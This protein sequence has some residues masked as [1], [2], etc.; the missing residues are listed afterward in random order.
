MDRRTWFAATFG[1]VSLPAVLEAQR[2]AHQA[3]SSGA[4]FSVLDNK[5]AREIEELTA[6]IIPTTSTPGAREARTVYF[7]DRALATFAKEHEAAYRSGLAD[8]DARRLKVFPRSESLAALQAAEKIA[9]LREIEK[10]PFF[11]LLRTHTMMAF[12]ADPAYGGNPEGGYQT[13][14]FRP[15]HRYQ[16]PFGWYDDKAN[17][18]EN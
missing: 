7:I 9:L 2:H 13:F 17:G 18:G 5:A 14:G 6:E 3:A 15:A 12:L 8:L 10:T 16:P 11:Q 1:M 4:G